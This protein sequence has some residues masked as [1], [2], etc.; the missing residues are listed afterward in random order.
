MNLEHKL[1]TLKTGLF[2]FPE[3]VVPALGGEDTWILDVG[4]GSGQWVVDMANEFPRA[5]V[6]GLDLTVASCDGC[7]WPYILCNTALTATSFIPLNCR[8]ELDDMNEKMFHYRSKFNF[9]HLRGV[10]DGISDYNEFLHESF[11]MLKPGG[12]LLTV[13]W[14]NLILDHN[15]IPIS[16]IRV[17]DPVSDRLPVLRAS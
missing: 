14:D 2:S 7:V 10:G 16:S 5:A 17:G 6:V 3:A 15:K 11:A 4:S 12:V 1:L 8:F 13:E 9:V